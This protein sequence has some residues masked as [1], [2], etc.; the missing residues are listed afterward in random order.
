MV[1][2]AVKVQAVGFS[3]GERLFGSA[4]GGWV[5]ACAGGDC[6]AGGGGSCGGGECCGCRGLSLCVDGE[7]GEGGDEGAE[8]VF[9]LH[10]ERVERWEMRVLGMVFRC[11]VIVV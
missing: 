3:D 7:G 4:S 2:Q 1:G 8:E 6:Y 10:F 11:V 5:A 9:G